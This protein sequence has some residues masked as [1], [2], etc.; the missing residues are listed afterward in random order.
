M[1]TASLTVR[2]RVLLF[3]ITWGT[4][5]V[6]AR[7]TS[8]TVQVAVAKNLVERERAGMRLALHAARSLLRAS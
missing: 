3:C 4:D 8:A 6:P 7:M 2:D 5:W 1:I